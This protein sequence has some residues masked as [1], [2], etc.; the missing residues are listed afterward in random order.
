LKSIRLQI[1]N[2]FINSWVGMKHLIIISILILIAWNSP[3]SYSET[4]VLAN[5][6][7]VIVNLDYGKDT[8]GL[9]RYPPAIQLSLLDDRENIFAQIEQLREQS[10]A[11]LE[12][13]VKQYMQTAEA[14][15]QL[16]VKTN[17]G[18]SARHTRERLLNAFKTTEKNIQ[19]VL[20]HYRT[21]ITARIQQ[22][23]IETLTL[24]DPT[25][26]GQFGNVTPGRYR[27][28]GVMTFATTTLRWFEPIVV[29]GGDRHTVDLTREN[30]TNP[31]WT[32]LNW[33]S[34]MN[35]DFSKHH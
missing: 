35:L 8:A 28:Y 34:F 6:G 17:T 25:V 12:P 9:T 16:A 20:E 2:S 32:D 33:W 23:T 3:F 26:N 7:E 13:L 18:Q 29:K 27:I 15:T 1:Q 30:M 31:Y 10:K 11:E 24:P 21:L 5:S 22:D 14:L 4:T 19:M